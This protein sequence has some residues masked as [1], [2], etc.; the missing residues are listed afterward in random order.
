MV[1]RCATLYRMRS[2]G[3]FVTVAAA[4]DIL[5]LT[6]WQTACLAATGDLTYHDDGDRLL[7]SLRSVL[8]RKAAQ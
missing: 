3:S 1:V 7:V 8:D 2:L 6:P 4:A 5:G